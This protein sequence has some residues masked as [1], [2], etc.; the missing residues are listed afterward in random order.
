MLKASVVAQK[1]TKQSVMIHPGRQEKCPFEIISVLKEVFILVCFPHSQMLSFFFNKYTYTHVHTLFH[2]SSPFCF[3]H[4]S[5][6]QHFFT[7]Q[8]EADL[9]RVAIAHIDR[10]LFKPESLTALAETGV[11]VE[12][13][14]WGQETR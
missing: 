4:F 11:N 9:S 2:I 13:D 8:S 14:M 5:F 1:T 6:S 7:L 10:T 12:L 3:L